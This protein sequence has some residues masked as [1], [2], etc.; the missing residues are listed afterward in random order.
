VFTLLLVDDNPDL[1]HVS[2]LV[3]EEQG[4]RV[5]TASNGK[6]GLATAIAHLPDAV[7]TD[8]HMPELDGRKLCRH[9]RQH[10]VLASMPVAVISAGNPPVE[11]QAP[12]TLFLRKPVDVETLTLAAARLVAGRLPRTSARPFLGDPARSRWRPVPSRCWP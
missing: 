1:R 8:W 4:Y 11:K 7:L 6:D 9:L 12:W 2:Q 5:L 10:A 3:L